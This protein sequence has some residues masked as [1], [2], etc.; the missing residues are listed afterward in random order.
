MFEHTK[1]QTKRQKDVFEHTKGKT[2]RQKDAFEHT[3]GQTNKQKDG[4]TAFAIF[5]IDANF[6]E[7][8]FFS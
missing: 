6:L 7:Y 1:R 4:Q 5:N 3:K 2:N 8:L